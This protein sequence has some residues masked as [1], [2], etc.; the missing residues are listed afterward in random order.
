IK[1]LRVQTTEVTDTRNG[2]SDQA[3]KEVIHALA[4]QRYLATDWPTSPDLESSNRFARLGDDDLLPADG[5]QLVSG[6]IQQLLV[7]YRFAHTHVQ[8]H[9]GDLGHAHR[10][11]IPK[12]F[13]KCGY[14]FVLVTFFQLSHLGNLNLC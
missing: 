7:T 3:V 2:D 6:I 5:S 11:V 12:L 4:T 13:G 14:R 8:D 10:I 1:S 9:L